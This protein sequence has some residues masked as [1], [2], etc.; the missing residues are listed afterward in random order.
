MELADRVLPDLLQAAKG[1]TEAARVLEK[2]DHLADADSRGAVLFQLFVDRYFS[3]P[4]GMAA[5]LRVKYDIS[6][7]ARHRARGSPIRPAALVALAAAAEEC[8]QTYGALDVKWGDVFRFASGN[9]DL[10]GNGGAGGSGLFR[11][12]AFTRKEGNKYYAANGETIVC[13]I[14]FARVPARA[15]HARLRQRQPARIAAPRGSVAADGA[16]NPAPGVAGAEGHRGEPRKARNVLSASAPRSSPPAA[17]RPGRRPSN[18][19]SRS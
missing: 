13:A 4:G 15:L 2:W 9:A 18:R 5:K 1:G 3:G 17:G 14:E 16:E 11:T 19:S 10:P 6:A 7:A 12:I 8:K